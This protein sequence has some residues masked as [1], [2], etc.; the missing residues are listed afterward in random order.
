MQKKRFPSPN[1]STM[2]PIVTGATMRALDARTIA[3]EQI[4][5]LTLMEQAGKAVVHYL[6]ERWGSLS[7]KVVTILCGKG[8]NGGDGFVVARLLRR[9]RAKP[10]V[11]LL[12]RTTDLQ[13]DAKVNYQ[14]W[15]RASSPRSTCI[16]PS[17]SQLTEWIN[18]GSL[19]IDALLGTGL[20]SPVQGS[21]LSAIHHLNSQERPILAIDIPS[22]LHADSGIILGEAV[23]A[24]ATVT[25]GLPKQGLYLN[26]GV[27]CAGTIH[28]ADIGIPPHLVHSLQTNIALLSLSF[29]QSILPAHPLSGHKGTF[30][31]IG[32]VAGSTGKTGAAALSANAALRTGSGLVTVAIPASVND[33]L[34]SKLLE[35]MTLPMPETAARTLGKK[36][37]SPLRKFLQTRTAAVIGPGLGSYPETVSL[38][39]TLIPTLP[40]PTVLDAD[41]L[42][43]IGG[44]KTTLLSK[45]KAPLILTPHPGEMA[46]L[47]N[48]SSPK[49]INADRIGLAKSFAQKHRV[50]VVLKGARS[51]LAHPNG[52]VA[53]CPTGNPGMAT[54]GSGDVLTGII[55]SFLGQGCSAWDAACLGTYTHGLAGDFA[56]QKLGECGMIA[57]DIVRHI[58]HTL[59]QL[60]QKDPKAHLLDTVPFLY[61]PV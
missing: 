5:G 20:S 11:L 41:A 36:A 53:I 29:A 43:A 45:A 60:N 37:L 24:T 46:R 33:T 4:S 54:A 21:Y 38:I 13:G 44:R 25:L 40:I 58:P 32:I 16:Q 3:E 26:Q 23:R 30:G 6:E 55:A 59:R 47:C 28:L 61:V 15:R 19:V 14:R 18:R 49:K 1:H 39:Q 57:S 34:E 52:H 50:I 12:T 31:H 42:N 48:F 56:A 7:G 22:G 9:K 51:V 27:D 35:V 8:N 10:Q 17:L 2:I